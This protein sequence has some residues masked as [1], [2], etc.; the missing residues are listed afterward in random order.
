MAITS[1]VAVYCEGSFIG[2]CTSVDQFGTSYQTPLTQGQAVCLDSLDADFNPNTDTLQFLAPS[3]ALGANGNEMELL[4][5]SADASGSPFT[6]IPQV[7]INVPEPSVVLLLGLG[8][9]GLWS[10]RKRLRLSA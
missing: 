8:L 4:F 6:A 7:S 3:C 9:F 2:S 1:G 10:E 5:G